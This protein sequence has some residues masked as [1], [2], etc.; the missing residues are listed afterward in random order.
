M[1]VKLQLPVDFHKCNNVALI[2]KNTARHQWIPPQ[3]IQ[4]EEQGK[5]VVKNEESF[6]VAVSRL[7]HFADI[8]PCQ[9]IEICHQLDECYNNSVH[10]VY[11]LGLTD[12][13]HLVPYP[14][15]K[16]DE[17][18]HYV[19]EV[20]IDP[21]NILPTEWKERFASICTEFS[22][23]IT[24]RPGRYNGYYGR[25][26]NSLNFATV[27]PPS[28][29]ARLPKYSQEM[30]KIL[31]EKMDKLEEWGVLV[32]PEDIGVVPEFVLPSMLT[33]KADSKDWRVVTDFTALNVHI[34][35]LET[36]SPTIKEAKEKIG[37]FNY[38]IQLD[39]S[40]Y[41]YQEGCVSKTVNT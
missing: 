16:A 15:A 35:K 19:L 29:K 32:K 27:P 13:S 3:L 38:H 23:V 12:V 1:S 9:E 33:P 2:P 25:V 7:E 31:G 28:I 39:L 21:D 14:Q 36:S 10:K 11:D 6:P 22:H 24:P 4:V 5:I 37:R 41:Y 18:P 26:D 8:L 30:M 20:S 40:N 34:K 17:G